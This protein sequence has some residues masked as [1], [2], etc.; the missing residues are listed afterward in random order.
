MRGRKS[1]N[2]AYSDTLNHDD[3]TNEA[4][5]IPPSYDLSGTELEL[6]NNLLTGVY[7]PV[8]LLGISIGNIGSTVTGNQLLGIKFRVQATMKYYEIVHAQGG[9]FDANEYTM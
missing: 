1:G 5:V 7:F 9:S 6:K 3:V 8:D 4:P 2:I